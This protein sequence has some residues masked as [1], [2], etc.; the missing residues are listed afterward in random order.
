MLETLDEAWRNELPVNQFQSNMH[1]K[2]PPTDL[3]PSN[4][5]II[6]LLLA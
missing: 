5:H 2:T 6:I 3:N 4:Q 1:D